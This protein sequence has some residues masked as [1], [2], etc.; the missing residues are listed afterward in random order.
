M[1]IAGKNEAFSVTV[2]DKFLQLQPIMQNITKNV[3][4]LT[5]NS[6]KYESK[7]SESVEKLE[8]MIS[9]MDSLHQQTNKKI[10]QDL[11]AESNQNIE[12]C[13]TITENLEKK[14]LENL[15]NLSNKDENLRTKTDKAI[16]LLKTNMDSLSRQVDLDR[17]NIDDLR[18]LQTGVKTNLEMI[19]DEIS[20]SVD[21]L[22]SAME[23]NVTESIKEV[24]REVRK[25]ED[26]ASSMSSSLVLVNG[27][28]DSL[29][30]KS[31]KVIINYIVFM[32]HHLTL[33]LSSW[34]PLP[35]SL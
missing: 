30:K 10:R 32:S 18:Q 9:A 27:N 14:V 3:H 20:R 26:R 15:E 17:V 19:K 5:Q 31:D 2:T 16:S 35:F 29:N 33:F 22:T 23:R 1:I 13:R 11:T 21:V 7:T 34:Q 6:S 12:K 25:L 28:V 8:K 4:D 24:E